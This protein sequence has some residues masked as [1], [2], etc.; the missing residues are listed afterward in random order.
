MPASL[1][2]ADDVGCDAD[3]GDGVVDNIEAWGL[4]STQT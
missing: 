2:G 4:K 1:V 3:R